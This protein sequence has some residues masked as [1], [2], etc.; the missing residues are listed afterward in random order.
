MITSAIYSNESGYYSL[1]LFIF[2]RYR[3]G[4]VI[5]VLVM[6][7]VIKRAVVVIVVVCLKNAP[8]NVYYSVLHSWHILY[9]VQRKGDM[10][11]WKIL[12]VCM[13]VCKAN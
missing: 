4:T 7:M 9:D 1:V 8:L 13:H 3:M 11:M 12:F 5:M 6:L 10:K 2:L